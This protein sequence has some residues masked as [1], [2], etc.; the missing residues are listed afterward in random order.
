[1]ICLFCFSNCNVDLIS[2]SFILRN[3]HFRPRSSR[4]AEKFI[5]VVHKFFYFNVE[6][7]SRLTPYFG[8]PLMFKDSLERGERVL[9]AP[10]KFQPG[11]PR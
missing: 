1:M 2:F 6:P 5:T 9:L 8:L 10:L 3:V 11:M 4:L 7:W